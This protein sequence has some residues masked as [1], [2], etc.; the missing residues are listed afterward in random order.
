M[1]CVGTSRNIKIKDK[2]D[3]NEQFNLNEEDKDNKIKTP[4]RKLDSESI[5]K[6]A[7]L[8]NNNM[9]YNE[10]PLN[11]SFKHLIKNASELDDKY[12][13]L[14]KLSKNPISTNYKIQSKEN[15]K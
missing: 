6:V 5:T 14:E 3:V 9:I 2:I 7:K 15:T 12:Y 11:I 1:G 10:S 13:I 8:S 4:E